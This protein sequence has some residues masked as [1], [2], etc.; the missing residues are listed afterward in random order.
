MPVNIA[1]ATAIPST[2]KPALPINASTA[3]PTAQSCSLM[4]SVHSGDTAAVTR[5]LQEYTTHPKAMAKIIITF[6][7]LIEKLNSSAAWGIVSNPT[8]AHGATATIARIPL[9]A[10]F[11][12]SLRL[13]AF[14][15][16]GDAVLELPIQLRVKTD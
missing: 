9:K 7:L 3:A 1:L 16:L 13:W 11:E 8:Y 14:P 12:R 6:T 15:A 10:C 4:N 5:L 2:T